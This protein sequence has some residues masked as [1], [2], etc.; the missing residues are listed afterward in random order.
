MT[1]TTGTS[2]TGQTIGRDLAFYN[3]AY[4]EA[5]DGSPRFIA[6]GEADNAADENGVMYSDNN[7]QSWTSVTTPY[8]NRWSDIAYGNG[9]WVAVS[10]FNPDEEISNVI[11]STDGGLNW[12]S[13]NEVLAAGAWNTVCYGN[14]MFIAIANQFSIYSYNGIDWQLG[15]DLQNNPWSD[16]VAG[17]NAAG[18]PMIV[19]VASSGNRRAT[20]S[21]TGTGGDIYTLEFA[22]NTNFEYFPNRALVQLPAASIRDVNPDSTPPTMEI[23]GGQWLAVDGTGDP[24]GETRVSRRPLRGTGIVASTNGVDQIT[25]SE[26][27]GDW[28]VGDFWIQKGPIF[29]RI[30]D[31]L[32]KTLSAQYARQLADAKLLPPEEIE[33]E[34]PPPTRKRRRNPDGTFA[35]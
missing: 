33:K 23:N 14:G 6:C 4:G 13:T 8:A 10:P 18:D 7:G 3:V 20:S 35:V 25:L 2:W 21:L 15:G 30:N 27:N 22:D 31:D 11:Y 12:N 32:P 1:S 16:C 5:A 26:T 29:R 19:A 34:S 17:Q 24:D 28:A 9:V